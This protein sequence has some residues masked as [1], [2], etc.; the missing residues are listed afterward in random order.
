MQHRL[1]TSKHNLFAI[2][3]SS[4]SE[5][6]EGIGY[7]G[8]LF[9]R[10]ERRHMI[11]AGHCCCCSPAYHCCCCSPACLPLLLLTYLPLL[12]LTCLPLLLLLTCLPLNY[13]K[14]GQDLLLLGVKPRFQL[15][16]ETLQ[17]LSMLSCYFFVCTIGLLF[18]TKLNRLLSISI[19]LF[20]LSDHPTRHILA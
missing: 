14:K 6:K 1:R 13:T 5:K 17:Q 10:E 2:S 16:S 18:S 4:L 3:A 15:P 8:R 12:L 20:C 11:H 7:A 19:L 9:I